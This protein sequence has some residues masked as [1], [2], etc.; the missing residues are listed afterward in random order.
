MMSG[1]I[2][3]EKDKWRYIE[4]WTIY[5]IILGVIGGIGAFLFFMLLQLTKG[6]F[7]GFLT[8]YYPPA[9]A[10]EA[11]SFPFPHTPF[12]LWLIAL[13][14]AVGGLIASFIT[15]FFA[16][17]AEGEGTDAVIDAFHNRGGVIRRRVPLVKMI[18]SAVTIGSGGSAGRE[19]PIMQIGGG[20]GSFLAS[21]ARLSDRD[22]RELV[23]CGAAAGLG[24][25]FKA[26][27]GGALF[28]VEVLYKRDFEMEAMIPAIV[29][30]VV[31]YA[32]FCSFPQIGFGPI[33]ETPQY[34]FTRPKELIF[35]AILGV[36]CAGLG[37]FYIRIFN[38]TR[39]FFRW[40]R[41]PRW[42]KPAIGGALV[43]IMAFLIGYCEP[44]ALD[45]V[46]CMG[47]GAIQLAVKGQLPLLILL[48]I[49][50][51]KMLATS[52]TIGSGG[53]GGVFAPSLT[54]GSMIGGF[55]GGLF[56]LLFPTVIT[57]PSAFVL[58]GMAAF[59]G[60]VAKVPIASILMVSEMTGSYSLLVPAM[61][62]V[63]IAYVL[64]GK[65]GIYE[66]QVKT[67]RESPVHRKEL[68]V[69]VLEGIKVEEAMVRDVSTVSP[70]DKVSDVLMK[71][72]REGHIGFPVVED[73]ELRGIVTFRDVEKV[74]IEERKEKRVD[75]IAVKKIVVTY[76]D[77]TLEKALQKL[78]TY[79]IGRLPVV[80]RVNKKR[81]LGII[82]K[83]DI[84]RAHARARAVE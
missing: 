80:D 24:A 36:A 62:S 30:S 4:I 77:E 54:I 51:S 66:K 5:S 58:V 84:I 29:C 39:N 65:A 21:H 22:K 53:S 12:R 73:G 23:I 11:F 14:P 35:Y 28:A 63:A 6:F 64:V 44:R 48:I 3:I 79:D 61:L 49:A 52:F 60:A 41:I 7:L 33:F 82:T 71:I 69:E 68:A 76:P 42:I 38:W 75:E 13:I 17:E 46:L 43:G 1:E 19:G 26:P 57:Q 18:A 67:R 81:L 72:E 2:R 27:L 50:I 45:G 10:G 55:F 15:Y 32:V 20:F 34:A 83:T 9:P 47:Y 56:Y 74:P 8:G 37:A 40:L 16:P 70:H 25:I 31:S 78:V 59:F